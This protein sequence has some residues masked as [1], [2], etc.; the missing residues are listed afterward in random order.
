MKALGGAVITL[1]AT[2]TLHAQVA[3]AAPGYVGDV[4]VVLSLRGG[5][6][7]LSAVVP[8]GDPQYYAMRPTIGV[9]RSRLLA[10]DSTFGLHP[11]LAPLLPLWRSRQLAAVTGVGAPDP[12]RSH[13]S[14]MAEMERAAPGS[15]LR[16]GWLD[17]TLGERAVSDDDVF[18]AVQVGSSNAPPSLAGPAP[19]LATSSFASFSLLGPRN[20]AERQRWS[21]CLEELHAS[22][23]PTV[24]APGR[25]AVAAAA[26]LGAVEPASTTAGY[27]ASELGRSLA[28]IARLVRSGV[29]VQA[30]TVDCG[31]WDM[32]E[33]LGRAGDGWMAAKL[34][35]LAA[36]L[37]A[38]ARDLGPLMA[39][40]TLVTLSEFGR[41]A[42]ENGSAGLDHGHGNTMFILGGGVDGGKVHGRWGGLG[43]A[44]LVDGAL[45]GTTDY[46]SVVGEV[47]VRRCGAGSLARIFPGLASTAPLGVVRP[48]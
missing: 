24:A 20:G 43:S 26:Q 44:G 35:D 10:L 40:T 47:L 21:A 28:D 19:E 3:M 37:A 4:L 31:D 14:A 41:R 1:A 39:S 48:R 16:T 32:H 22:G 34:A 46:R 5:F 11:A 25:R 30:A 27:P 6:D 33:D 13:F 7:G 42:A 38:F 29:G 15:S 23:P 18:A 8:G 9:P 45:A 36:S 2:E 17:R 12:T